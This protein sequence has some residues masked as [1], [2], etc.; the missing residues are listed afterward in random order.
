M[1]NI[2]FAQTGIKVKVEQIDA[3]KQVE[4]WSFE[5]NQPDK[6]TDS[7]NQGKWII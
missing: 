6:K 5:D 4:N 2:I 7:G 1:L 3:N